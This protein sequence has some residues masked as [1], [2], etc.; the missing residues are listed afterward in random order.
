ME[1]VVQCDL[2][3]EAEHKE[4]ELLISTD[5]ILKYQ[6]NLEKRSIAIAFLMTASVIRIL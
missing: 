4:Y 6:Q 1:A 5:P 3:A 2:I